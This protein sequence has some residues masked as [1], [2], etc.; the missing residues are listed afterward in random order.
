MRELFPGIFEDRI[1]K[2]AMLLTKSHVTEPHFKERIIE[3]NGTPYREW[4]PRTSKLAAAIVKG[5]RE[6]CFREGDTVLYLGASHG[7]T[8]SYISDILGESGTIVAVDISPRVLR[9]LVYIAEKRNNIMPVLADAAHPEGYA[10]FIKQADVLYQD[11]A[12]RNQAEI[13]MLNAD[14]FLRPGGY[15]LIALKARSIDSVKNPQ[16]VFSEVKKQLLQPAHRLKLIDARTLEP[17]DRD[18]MF[19]VFRKN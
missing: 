6:R 5:L 14:R 12:Q 11:I 13:F 3:S 7:V 16:H 19:M 4:D 17:F 9:S 15:A 2:K 10:D 8:A 1:G 18:H